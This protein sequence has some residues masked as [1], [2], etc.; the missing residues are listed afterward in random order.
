MVAEI[1]PGQLDEAT[2]S[3]VRV[4]LGVVTSLAIARIL[5]GLA[6]FAQNRRKNTPYLVH[7]LWAIFLLLLIA[8]F[9][10]FEF[11]LA[12]VGAWPFEAYAFLIFFASLHFFTAALLFPDQLEEGAP[13]EDYFFEHRG[14]FF[15]FLGALFLFDMV[16][17][18]L[19]GA[20]YFASLGALYPV[21]QVGYAIACAAA[22]RWDNRRFHLALVIGFI[23]LE[24]AWIVERYAD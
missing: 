24:M 3:H 17:T 20:D 10:W 16:D 7:T 22:I 15:G 11:A 23:L 5:N 2:F 1:E 9:W 12:Q 13:Y 14:W 21:R 19:K 18:A 8:H 4:I 6:G